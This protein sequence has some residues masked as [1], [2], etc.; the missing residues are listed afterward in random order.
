MVETKHRVCLEIVSIH[1]NTRTVYYNYTYLLKERQS[2]D[3]SRETKYLLATIAAT[4]Y[5]QRS[6]MIN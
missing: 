5:L 1:V 2:E 3:S 4:E 6:H